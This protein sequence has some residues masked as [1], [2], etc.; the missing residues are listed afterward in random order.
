LALS[1]ALV[2]SCS[3]DDG[4]SAS[5]KTSASAPQASSVASKPVDNRLT[6]LQRIEDTRTID[7]VTAD[8]L[9]HADPRVRR[10]A[11]RALARAR[12]GDARAR[13]LSTLADGDPEVL[14]W[15]AYGLG[16][17]CRW[18]RERSAQRLIT[19][20]TARSIEPSPPAGRLDPWFAI[21]RAL[22]RCAS[23]HAETTLLAWLSGPKSRSAAA[24]KGLGSV[25]TRHDRMKEETAAALLRATRGDAAN[26]PLAE[27]LYPFGRLK[28]APARVQEQLIEACRKRMGHAVP[29]RVLALRALAT[30]GD[31]GV[32]PLAAVLRADTG[33]TDAEKA[34]AARALGKIGTKRSH[35]ALLSALDTLVPTNDPVALTSLVGPGF[36]TL[37]TVFASLQPSGKR[38]L[39]S[40]AL[41]TMSDLDFPPDAP[42]A[43]AHRIRLLRCAAARLT[44]GSAFRHPLVVGCD[45]DHGTVGAL[46]RLAVIDRGK[47]RGARLKAWKGYLDERHPPIVRETAIRL[48]AS[49][50]EARETR[51]IVAKALRAKPAGVVTEAA[52]LVS[53]HPSRFVTDES[54]DD[55]AAVPSPEIAEALMAAIEREWPPDAIE[56]RGALARACGAVGLESAREWLQALCKSPN[57]TLRNHARRARQAWQKAPGSCGPESAATYDP[58]AELD[59]LVRAPQT[60]ELDTDVGKLTIVLDPDL[61]PVA[62]TR[63]TDL[64]KAE[65]YDGMLVHRVVPGFV[66]QFGDREGDGY[67]GANREPLRCEC[68][69]VPFDEGVVGLALGGRDTGS[70]QLFVT[71]G[72]A[73]HLDGDYPVV[74]KAFGAWNTLT[75][76]DR[77]R[78]VRIVSREPAGTSTPN[79]GGSR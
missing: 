47:L 60:L 75:V 3:R 18:D 74:G 33:Y 29:A 62:A 13:L 61:A 35:E 21:G 32:E 36:G 78:T 51:E 15:S 50:P 67:G 38:G 68:S 10:A 19:R 54:K 28:R 25:V 79:G 17:I 70:S 56:T 71:L 55:D 31:D 45:P 73:P 59:H 66:V 16:S 42:R 5:S 41:G 4:P 46:A 53:S 64:V 58:A 43:V 39:K 26:D 52:L 76:G 49:H 48:M 69:P 27:A 65:F 77:I 8:D 22:G 30:L 24:A 37:M 11:V 2:S 14:A 34:E 57:P 6:A 63:V 9:A 12:R 1:T 20:A 72:P 40:P 44:A 23:E 7:E